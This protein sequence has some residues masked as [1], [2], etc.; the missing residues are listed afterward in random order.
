[1]DDAALQ[2]DDPPIAPTAVRGDRV[3]ELYKLAVEMADRTSARRATANAF[4]LTLNSALLAVVGLV[5]PAE[6]GGAGGPVTDRFGVVLLSVAGLAL[7]LSWWVLLRSY[8]DLNHAK[9]LVVNEIERQF[10]VAPFN[11]EWEHLKAE[12]S[13]RRAWARYIELGQVERVVPLVYA[14]VYVA[15]VIRALFFPG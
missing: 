14:A 5:K 15:A 1:M 13:S 11:E 2:A 9:F 12:R 10:P 8:K 7:A 3:L 6:G 4:F